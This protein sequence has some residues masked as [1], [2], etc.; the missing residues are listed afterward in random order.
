MNARA[1]CGTE[2]THLHDTIQSTYSPSHSHKL[3]STCCYSLES[4][5]VC[6]ICPLIIYYAPS[7]TLCP[8]PSTIYHLP[9]T[10]IQHSKQDTEMSSTACGTDADSHSHSHSHSHPAPADGWKNEGV[11]VIPGNSLDSDTHP[12]PGMNRAAAVNLARVGAQKIVRSSRSYFLL[13]SAT[14]QAEDFPLGT[15]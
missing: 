11:R 9:S 2:L 8:L 12:T 10:F 3:T 6:L 7:P 15:I 4:R 14:F 5:I 1:P 13:I